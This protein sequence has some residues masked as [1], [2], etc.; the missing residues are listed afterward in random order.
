MNS[1]RTCDP[2]NRHPN[3]LSHKQGSKMADKKYL[4]VV[5]VFVEIRTA[6]SKP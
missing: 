6:L 4:E 3:K 5:M 1:L 2:G